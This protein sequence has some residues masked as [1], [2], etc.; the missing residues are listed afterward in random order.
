MKSNTKWQKLGLSIGLLAALGTPSCSDTE[1]TA[2]NAAA[3]SG[4]G[5]ASDGRLMISTDPGR[6]DEI[7]ALPVYDVIESGIDEARAARLAEALGLAENALGKGR[8]LA[9]DGAIRSLDAERFQRVPTR[10]IPAEE[11]RPDERGLPTARNDRALD[12]DA[13]AALRVL[14]DDEA[15]TRVRT[16]LSSA[17]VPSLQRLSVSHSTFEAVTKEGIEEASVA[18]DT[19]V[20]GVFELEGQRLVGPGAKLKVVFDGEGV[21]TQMVY[22]T[23]KLAR[24]EEVAIVP[25]SQARRLCEE[26]FGAM[27]DVSV[28]SELVYYAPP[29][30][31]RVGRIYPHYVCGGTAQVG[32]REISLRRIMVPALL[33]PAKAD[34]SVETRE[35]TALAPAA[36]GGGAPTSSLVASGSSV[37]TEW[38]GHCGGLS[39][40]SENANGFAGVFASNGAAVPFNRGNHDAKE[41]NFKDPTKGGND[42]EFADDVDMTFFTG[43]AHPDGFLF[44]SS[45]T[46]QDLTFQDARWGQTGVE[47]MVVAACDLLHGENPEGKTWSERWGRAFEG[48]HLLLAYSNESYDNETEGTDLATYLLVNGLSVRQAWV[49]A[50]TNSQPSDTNYAFMGTYGSNGSMPNY[51]DHFWGMGSVGNDQTGDEIKGFWRI[52][53]GC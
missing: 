48:L 4:A 28:T 13:L 41:K 53:G 39:G 17:A 34:L 5:G 42:D 25:P 27:G 46:D 24:G 7:Q 8:V 1:R 49:Q 20:D 23:R 3:L 15:L 6:D 37:G 11:P 21:V 32:G 16:A 50:A 51:D 22:A 33:E 18:L 19:Q 9:E 10:M 45:D 35:A 36:M 44:C 43:H 38:I 29:L 31:K 2:S 12:F 52:K 30:S 26:A 14:P 47:W 40:S